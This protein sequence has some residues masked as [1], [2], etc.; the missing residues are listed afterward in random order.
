M[1]KGSLLIFSHRN[2]AGS[3]Y[4]A[5]NRVQVCLRSIP[6]GNTGQAICLSPE[7]TR[8]FVF[9]HRILFYNLARKYS[10]YSIY[11]H[12]FTIARWFMKYRATTRCKGVILESGPTCTLRSLYNKC[13]TR[14]LCHAMGTSWKSS[15]ATDVCN[16]QRQKKTH[17][18]CR[19]IRKY[20]T[21]S[22]LLTPRIYEDTKEKRRSTLYAVWRC[23]KSKEWVIDY[24]ANTA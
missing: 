17:R 18:R 13:P 7:N 4:H 14:M 8:Y 19:V 10:I 16:W 11:H 5:K 24:F 23:Q 20:A 3:K 2:D 21:R 6:N 22:F 15:K 9:I 12:L 1:I